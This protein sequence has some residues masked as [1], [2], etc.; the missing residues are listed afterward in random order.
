ETASL[1]DAWTWAAGS[2]GS[3]GVS[4][5]TAVAV[6]SWYA[7]RGSTATSSV[8][9]V[10]AL[11]PLAGITAPTATSATRAATWRTGSPPRLAARPGGPRQC[12]KAP[13]TSPGRLHPGRPAAPRAAEGPRVARSWPRAGVER[14][15][16]DE[17]RA[18]A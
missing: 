10:V 5:G 12:K 1:G 4:V 2:T 11:T 16:Q 8:A 13:R 17:R 15:P 14:Q 18:V 9:T 6:S 7:G 3:V